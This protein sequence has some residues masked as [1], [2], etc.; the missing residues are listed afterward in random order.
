MM[1]GPVDR[2]YL[3]E[4]LL[5]LLAIP[6]PCGLTDEIVHAVGHRLG[7]L[8][9]P[10]ELTRRGTIR[11][12]LVGRENSPDRAIVSHLDTIGMMV[13]RI[14]DDGR[15]LLAPIGRWA[16][17]FAEGA[18]VTLFSAQGALRGTVLPDV[19]W[20]RSGDEG[21]NEPESSWDHV[22]L[23]LEAPVCS[24]RE[25]RALGVEVGD[26]LAM[27]PQPEFLDNGLLVARHLDN[28]AGTATV[29]TAL[30]YI[31]DQGLELPLGCH[32]LF[33]V[34]EIIGTGTAG[35]LFPDVSELVTVDFASLQRFEPGSLEAV[36]LALQ[37]ASGP[38]DY[39]LTHHLLDI[40]RRQ[41][42]PVRTAVL[43]AHHR[44]SSSAI[45]A[46]HDVRTAVMT[47]SG[48]AAHS[49]ERVHMDSLCNLARLLVGYL[50]SDPLFPRDQR[51]MASLEGFP[52]QIRADQWPRH[53]TPLPPP[54]AWLHRLEDET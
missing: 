11:A 52:H 48:H 39:H 51:P 31:R 37:D 54:E 20:G 34:T 13:R 7:E 24:Q 15:I 17:R 32:P 18:R 36:T 43:E 22:F 49:I 50:T 30:K 38:F 10:Y 45:V 33:T 5:H 12:T 46:G 21:A 2:D 40:A 23:R 29:L 26:Y 35:A 53:E 8:G 47:Y 3:R 6:S 42:I 9:I 44:D 28:K 4:T 16:S 14:K 19:R 27:D 41:E 1:T 25:V